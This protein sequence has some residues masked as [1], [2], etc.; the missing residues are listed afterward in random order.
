MVGNG[1][2]FINA[3]EV[4]CFEFI[5]NVSSGYFAFFI[6]FFFK[7]ITQNMLTQILSQVMQAAGA[8]SVG[9]AQCS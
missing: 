5:D 7:Q 6:G 2:L 3:D 8:E 9:A 4:L 1:F